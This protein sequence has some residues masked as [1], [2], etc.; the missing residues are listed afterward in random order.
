MKSA[1]DGA[2]TIVATRLPLADAAPT[3]TG[4]GAGG[5]VLLFDG[6]GAVGA[7]GLVAL[8]RSS[9]EAGK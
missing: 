8:N 2:L 4:L 5:L 1:A 6:L 7:V 3:A 9:A